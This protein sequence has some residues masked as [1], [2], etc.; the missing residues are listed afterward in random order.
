MAGYKEIESIDLYTLMSQG[1]ILL[2]DVR[3]DDETSKGMI[4][5]AQPI[6]LHLLPIRADELDVEAPLIF[7]CHSGMRSAQ[8]SQFMINKGRSEV[9]NLRGG[10]LAWGTAGYPIESKR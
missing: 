7:Y 10:I 4:Q 3:T 6:P 2:V 1:K 5:G 9:Y 8:A